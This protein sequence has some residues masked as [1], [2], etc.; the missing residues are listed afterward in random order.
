VPLYLDRSALTFLLFSVCQ[1]EFS[2]GV[3]T[4]AEASEK[5]KDAYFVMGYGGQNVFLKVS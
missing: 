1:S 5:F 2:T 4:L 3:G